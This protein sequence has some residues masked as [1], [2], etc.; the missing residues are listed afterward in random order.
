MRTCRDTAEMRVRCR[1][2][3][4][5]PVRGDED[6]DDTLEEGEHRERDAKVGLP[7][8]E[9]ARGT[10]HA[11]ELEQSQ[12]PEE[13]KVRRVRRGAAAL[14][15][16]LGVLV[17]RD[18]LCTRHAHAIHMRMHVCTH[19][20]GA[21]AALVVRDHHVDRH[22]RRHVERHPGAAVVAHDLP[23]VV[24]PAAALVG[25]LLP[26]AGAHAGSTRAGERRSTRVGCAWARARCATQVRMRVPG[27]RGRS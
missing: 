14:G 10:Q 21:C 18:D 3:A 24:D 9:D 6:E 16:R 2:D 11:G 12:H 26:A 15:V 27:R 7:P 20:W 13:P 4:G 25:W 23:V 19:A 17:V 1:G 22:R 5:E 8:A